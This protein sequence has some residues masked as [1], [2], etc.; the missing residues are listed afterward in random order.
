ML[1][2]GT[3]EGYSVC[4]EIIVI[5]SILRIYT[6]A[7]TNRPTPKTHQENQKISEENKVALSEAKKL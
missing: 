6:G 4:R 5:I 1:L 2:I 7:A 3:P